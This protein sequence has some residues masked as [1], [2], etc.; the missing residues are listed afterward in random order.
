M[1]VTSLHNQ[2]ENLLLVQLLL[3]RLH[4]CVICACHNLVE[5]GRATIKWHCPLSCH[6][7]RKLAQHRS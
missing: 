6:K 4:I 1:T 2:D 7:S 5:P 3:L